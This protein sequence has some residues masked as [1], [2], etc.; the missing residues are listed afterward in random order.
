MTDINYLKYFNIPFLWHGESFSGVDCIGLVKLFYKEE[1]NIALK[2]LPA[3]TEDS[4]DPTNYFRE[5]Y[6]KFG[7]SI[8]TQPKFGDV[9]TFKNAK[10]IER[11]CA[12]ILTDSQALQAD[13][14][15]VNVLNYKTDSR[16][17]KR[18]D[19]FYTHRKRTC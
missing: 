11:H 8:T 16:W 13:K 5:N 18:L 6:K 10:G 17:L 3:Y 4:A 14:T 9:V 15:G 2:E 1:F 7:F 19:T 12:I